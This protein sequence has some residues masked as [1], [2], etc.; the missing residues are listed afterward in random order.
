[1]VEVADELGTGGE[2]PFW[3]VLEKDARR[4]PTI[5]SSAPFNRSRL[6]T[7]R[8]IPPLL[9]PCQKDGVSNPST[10]KSKC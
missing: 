9:V 5:P 7:V 3:C 10:M 1:M 2:N 8:S 6:E 4:L